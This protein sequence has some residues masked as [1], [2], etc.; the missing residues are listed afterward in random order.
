MKLPTLAAYLKSI[1]RPPGPP[2]SFLPNITLTLTR[3]ERRYPNQAVFKCPTYLNKFD[4]AN[5]LQAIYGIKAIR[6]DTINYPTRFKLDPDR[7][8]KIPIPAFKKAI[9]TLDH[10]FVYP[11]TIELDRLDAE[12]R[13]RIVIPT[14]P[15]M[16]FQSKKAR[17]YMKGDNREETD[18][19]G[20]DKKIVSAKSPGYKKI[21]EEPECVQYK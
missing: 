10:E 13:E 20:K 11:E 7:M 16:E 15:K 3:S 14:M 21:V 19:Y 9:V 8:V 2:K 5:Y 1:K 18:F 6:V 4:V 17:K 12:T